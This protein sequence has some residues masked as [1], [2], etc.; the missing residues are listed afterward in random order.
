MESNMEQ[1]IQLRKDTHKALYN[2]LQKRLK[3]EENDTMGQYF[4]NPKQ[5]ED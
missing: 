2:K 3:A 4:Y 5:I 1:V